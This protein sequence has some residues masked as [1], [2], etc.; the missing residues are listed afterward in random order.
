MIFSLKM[1]KAMLKFTG[2][3][4]RPALAQFAKNKEGNLA[5]IN[6]Y[7]AVWTGS[8]TRD[9]YQPTV[10][11]E[12]AIQ[13]GLVKKQTQY[14]TDFMPTDSSIGV[15]PPMHRV[16]GDDENYPKMTYINAKYLK[17][18]AELALSVNKDARVG[19]SIHEPT[20]PVRFVAGIYGEHVNGV[21]MPMSAD[22]APVFEGVK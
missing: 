17:E 7:V 16:I 4:Y 5:A 21:I 9:D 12:E 6:T 3:G 15:Y 19:L 1:L 22:D 14:D 18:I 8:L 10:G 20:R 2:D 11:V 13:I